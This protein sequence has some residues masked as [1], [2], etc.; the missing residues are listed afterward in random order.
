MQRRNALQMCRTSRCIAHISK[1][2]RSAHLLFWG[3]RRS[4][5]IAVYGKM[6]ANGEA[7]ITFGFLTARST[8]LPSG[9][10]TSSESQHSPFRVQTLTVPPR[11]NC[12]RLLPHTSL[13]RNIN[14]R[15][16]FIG[17]RW[18]R[19]WEMRYIQTPEMFCL[20]HV[21]HTLN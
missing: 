12:C 21:F 18:P 11:I 16:S 19:H 3:K 5:S 1:S 8:G 17:G 2:R 7:R 10:F 6:A 15:A 20:A 14:L 9:T 13:Y 4:R